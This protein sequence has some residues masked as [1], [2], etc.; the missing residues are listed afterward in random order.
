VRAIGIA[1][2]VFG[3]ALPAT[4]VAGERTATPPQWRGDVDFMYRGSLEPGAIRD[5][6]AASRSYTLV[7]NYTRMTHGLDITARFAVVHGITIGLDVPL[8]FHQQRRWLEGYDMRFDPEHGKATM[9]AARPLPGDV[10]G[11]SPSARNHVGIGDLGILFRFVPFAER[12]VPGR[13]AAATLALDVGIRAPSGENHDAVREDGTAGPGRGGPALELGMTA[14]RRVK[15]VEPYIAVNAVLS[16][17]YRQLVQDAD[18]LDI[19]AADGD[20]EGTEF[21]PA[22]TI[23]VRFGTEVALREVPETDERMGLDVGIG[24]RYVG[25]HEASVGS[26]I[27]APLDATVGRLGVEAEHIE[28]DFGLGFRIRPRREIQVAIDVGVGWE[29][30]HTL[31]IIDSTSYTSQTSP[32]TFRFFWGLGATGRIR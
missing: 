22:D 9:V 30:P 11:A 6:A 24:L 7:G 17:P 2:A 13:E 16:A 14:S 20:P 5:R 31:E 23:G 10:L 19:P 29:S 1:A 3:L 26:W 28:V 27:P 32:G 4:A 8:V 18:G 12:G 15:L 25:P 21:D